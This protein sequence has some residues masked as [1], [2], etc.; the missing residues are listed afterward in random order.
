M[1]VVNVFQADKP[2]EKEISSHCTDLLK[3]FLSL[4]LAPKWQ[5]RLL[6]CKLMNYEVKKH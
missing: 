2:V 5:I 6:I 1:S 4:S 3:L